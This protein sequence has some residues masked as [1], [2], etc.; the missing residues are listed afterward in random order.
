M[1]PT[2]WLYVLATLIVLVGISGLILPALPGG[3]V[4]FVGL[5]VAAWADHFEYVGLGWLTVLAILT[6]ITYSVDL[7]AG[8]FGAKRFGASKQSVVGAAIGAVVGIFFGIPGIILGPFI[9]AVVG[10]LSQRPDLRAAGRAGLGA[11]LGLVLGIAAKL[12]LAFTMI[13]LFLVI[14]FF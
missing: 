9:A 7:I 13:G 3:P 12:S 8:A 11:T 5:L 1:D 14:R 10:E 4:I 2:P 6:A